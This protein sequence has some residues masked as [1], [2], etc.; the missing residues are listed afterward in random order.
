MLSLCCA[1]G[2]ITYG[3]VISGNIAGLTAVR[4]VQIHLTF[5]VICYQLDGIARAVLVSHRAVWVL[6]CCFGLFLPFLVSV[7]MVC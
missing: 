6:T 3:E 5:K 2:T 1:Y 7:R 4:E